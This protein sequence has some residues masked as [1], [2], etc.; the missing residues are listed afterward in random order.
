MRKHIILLYLL[1][2]SASCFAQ[3]VTKTVGIVYTA[4]APAHAPAAK[5]GSQVAI[6]T[7]TW[8]WYEYNGSAWIA[9]G[10]RIQ[11]ISG[12]SAPAYTPTKFQSRLAINAC[13]ALQGG[14]ELYY[15]TG[16]AWLQINE[17]QTYT[18][19]TGISITGTTIANT[20]DLSATNEIQTLS[21]SGSDLSISSGNT[22]TLPVTGITSLNGQTG[23]T[24]TFSTGTS[25][26][27]FAISSSG[28]THTFNLPTA[29]ASSRGLLTASNW[30]AFNSK[31][32]GSG[33][34]GRV[35]LW[36]SSSL[37]DN[38]A[39][40]YTG[41]VLQSGN[42]TTSN[43]LRLWKVESATSS[44]SSNDYENIRLYNGNTTAGNWTAIHSY[45][46]GGSI[47]AG[48]GFK[49]L[50]HST[51]ES[52]THIF[53]RGGTYGFSAAAIFADNL[54]TLS[55]PTTMSSTSTFSGASTFNGAIA[56][57]N[58]ATF[59][60]APSFLTAI[61]LGNSSTNSKLTAWNNYSSTGLAANNNFENIKLQNGNTTDNNYTAIANY[62]SGG[63][64]AGGIAFQMRSHASGYADV[65]F[66]NR[67]ASGFGE[68]ARFQDRLLGAGATSPTSKVDVSG[69]T[70]Y[71][72]FRLRQTYTPTSSADALGNTGDV[73]WDAGY[74]YI[75][76]AS[77][78]KRAALSTF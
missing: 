2:L 32:S 21:L 54:I 78:W 61:T 30:S 55:R 65:V 60:S 35:A 34:S 63:N 7:A 4:G 67:G 18:A 5:V 29:S 50:N 66:F 49:M 48:I 17:G 14:P 20:G 9:S 22:V 26:T 38:S 40:T 72:Q 57:N 28:N 62:T 3:T 68:A 25:G 53:S 51:A 52:E 16:S 71:K 15:Y 41:T 64:I 77:G 33:T 6:D 74:I 43:Q 44:A 1:I 23:G 58:T 69:D 46:S 56:I 10:D 75:K 31:V 45:T 76:T 39:F 73:A 24:Q 70:G 59:N 37:T 13:T 12:C 47:G 11:S 36:G 27:D 19:G 42:S 8:E